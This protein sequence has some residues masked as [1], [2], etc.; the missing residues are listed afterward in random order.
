[1]CSRCRQQQHDQHCTHSGRTTL[2]WPRSTPTDVD[3]QDEQPFTA[4]NAAS[5]RAARQRRPPPRHMMSS[6][7]S[8]RFIDSR[9]EFLAE[10]RRHAIVL[11]R[12][13]CVWAAL[14]WMGPAPRSARS[15]VLV[16]PGSR[17]SRS[18]GAMP[19]RQ[20]WLSLHSCRRAANKGSVGAAHRAS[21]T[22][23]I[24]EPGGGGDCAAA[25]S[26]L[27]DARSS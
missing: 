25:L 13:V 16:Q 3:P 27:V 5:C 15:R 14:H 18:I 22:V 9:L 17:T 21:M 1:V 19:S 24:D 26:D 23:V 7:I 6:L 12:A 20:P 4:A 10:K 8:C 2:E 11:R